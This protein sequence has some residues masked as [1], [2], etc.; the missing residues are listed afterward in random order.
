[1]TVLDVLGTGVM[2]D[3]PGDSLEATL[4]ST[5]LPADGDGV[6]ETATVALVDALPNGFN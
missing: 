3:V 4:R 1:M 5:S 6:V 2:L